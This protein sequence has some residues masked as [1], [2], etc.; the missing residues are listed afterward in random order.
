MMARCD[1]CVKFD[2]CPF[3]YDLDAQC[4][5]FERKPMTNGD[6]IRAFS[7]SELAEFLASIAACPLCKAKEN[8][9][10]C[11]AVSMGS[12]IIHWKHWLR[13]EATDEH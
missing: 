12:C 6:K 2:D 7:Y 9:K 13:E 1:L 4:S 11:S 3:R 10:G 8:C 5:E